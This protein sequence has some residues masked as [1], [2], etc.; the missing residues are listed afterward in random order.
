MSTLREVQQALQELNTRDSVLND[1]KRALEKAYA[2][3]PNN[4]F[5]GGMWSGGGGPEYQTEVYNRAVNAYNS[6]LDNFYSKVDGLP[7]SYRNAISSCN[8]DF[9][10]LRQVIGQL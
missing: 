8:Q 9:N 1:S 4:T 6:A 3:N 10:T 5:G 7:V 2:I